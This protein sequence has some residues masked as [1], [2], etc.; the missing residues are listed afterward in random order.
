[1][2]EF[3]EAFKVRVGA[4]MEVES[5][6][7]AGVAPDRLNPVEL[8]ILMG[9]RDT[10]N[11]DQQVCRELIAAC[12]RKMLKADATHIDHTGTVLDKH[13]DFIV[14][15]DDARRYFKSLGLEPPEGSPLWCWTCGKRA[16]DAGKLRG[17]QQDKADFQQLCT[18]Y[19]DRNPTA[20]IRGESGATLQAGKA[21]LRS[22]QPK[23]LE[24]WASEVAPKSVKKPG[25]PQKTP[26]KNPR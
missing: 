1:M 15:R 3:S 12:T 23:T 4:A 11:L 6:A 19:W 16:E 26:P 17:D 25:R 20:T 21:Y 5:R 10:G 2:S 24:Q 13:V 7:L 14:H 9:A 22:Y 18:E 8:A